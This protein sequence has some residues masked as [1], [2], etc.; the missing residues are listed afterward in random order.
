MRILVQFPTLGRPEKFMECLRGYVST[1]SDK[2]EVFFNI[3]CDADDGTM[4]NEDI[5]TDIR[6]LC[7]SQNCDINFLQNSTKISAINDCM[8]GKAFDIVIVVS[9]DMNVRIDN[10]DDIICTDMQKH[11]PELD[12]ALNYNDGRAKE[13]L[14][15]FSILGRAL[16]E[17]FGYI[18]HPD[19]KVLYCDNEFTEEVVRMGKVVYRDVI[20]FSHDHYAEEGN[21]NSGDMDFAARKTLHFSGRDGAVYQQRKMLGFPRERVTHD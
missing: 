1:M 3:N 10:W 13:E 4:K 12:G 20:L 14:I 17:E 21:V 9:D 2:H 18:Y 19:Y 8:D 11:F 7:G 15:T 16:Y 5:Q 6:M